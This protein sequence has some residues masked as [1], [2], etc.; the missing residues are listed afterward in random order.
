MDSMDFELD[1]ASWQEYLS[2]KPIID[3]VISELLIDEGDKISDTVAIMPK[4]VSRYFP[5]PDNWFITSNNIND[6]VRD[7]STLLWLAERMG[8]RVEN[9]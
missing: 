6:I 7:G 2:L 3:E 9:N 4:A 5:N 8:D 1:D